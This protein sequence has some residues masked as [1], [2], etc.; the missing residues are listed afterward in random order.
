MAEASTNPNIVDED[1]ELTAAQK[2]ES[3]AVFG[4]DKQPVKD[5]V[6]FKVSRLRFFAKRSLSTALYRWIRP[7]V[8]APTTSTM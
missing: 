5:K 7:I 6:Y 3:A 1:E 2:Q 8:V 4:D